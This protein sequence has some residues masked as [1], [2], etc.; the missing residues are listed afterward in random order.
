[1]SNKKGD[2]SKLL[3]GTLG[4]SSPL[5]LQAFLDGKS[6]REF[7][8]PTFSPR[9]PR[10]KI[11]IPSLTWKGPYSLIESIFVLFTTS[12]PT[13]E[14]NWQSVFLSVA[15]P[16]A[17]VACRRRFGEV[18]LCRRRRRRQSPCQQTSTFLDREGERPPPPPPPSPPIPPRRHVVASH[19]FPAH[20]LPQGRGKE[21]QV[22]CWS[23]GGRRRISDIV[24]T[25]VQSVIQCSTVH[26]CSKKRL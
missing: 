26:V 23:G 21:G 19:L 8:Y 7:H 18:G 14:Y 12:L 15:F 24:A 16:A 2:T 10:R 3:C 9:F 17:A 25:P 13:E 5:P 22:V 4:T 20:M 1:M 6:R 11:Y